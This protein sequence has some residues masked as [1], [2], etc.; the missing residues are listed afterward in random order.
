MNM[1]EYKEYLQAM[2]DHKSEPKIVLQKKPVKT[3]RLV[4]KQ[5]VKTKKS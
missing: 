1:E 4:K 5:F 3:S 2:A